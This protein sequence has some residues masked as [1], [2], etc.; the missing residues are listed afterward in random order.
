MRVIRVIGAARV[1]RAVGVISVIWV[2]R[3]YCY[4]GYNGY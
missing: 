1:Y 2:I 4:L 3:L